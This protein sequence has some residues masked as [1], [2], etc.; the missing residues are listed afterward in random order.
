[1]STE[2]RT[3]HRWAIFLLAIFVAAAG[4]MSG[5]EKEEKVKPGNLPAA[6]KSAFNKAYPNA[7]ITGASTEKENGV[8]YYEIESLDGKVRRDLLYTEDGSVA[9]IEETISAKALPK[10]IHEA[11]GKEFPKAE[12]LRAEKTTRGTDVTYELRI[13]ETGKTREVVFDT[14]GVVLKKEESD[15]K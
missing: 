4:S 2:S 12:I 3:R 11:F 6:V 15:E 14:S 10:K 13:K 1:M 5:Q 9:E 8:T 7:K